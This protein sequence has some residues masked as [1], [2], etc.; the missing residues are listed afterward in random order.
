MTPEE[1]VTARCWG[2]MFL[3]R[4]MVGPKYRELT[5]EGRGA[6]VDFILKENLDEVFPRGQEYRDIPLDSK[7]F[8]RLRRDSSWQRLRVEK[9]SKKHKRETLSRALAS[10]KQYLP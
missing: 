3:V 10:D 9:R 5:K 8:L 4:E 1:S 7:L 2:G 6:I